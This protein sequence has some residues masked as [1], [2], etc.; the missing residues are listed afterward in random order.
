MN[1]SVELLMKGSNRY[2]SKYPNYVGET[3]SWK[4]EH[5]HYISPK[6]TD[7]D[8]LM[9]GMIL[10]HRRMEDSEIIAEFTQR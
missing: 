6:P 5:I 10:S 1:F 3:D 9:D 2:L 4:N 8:L 7:I